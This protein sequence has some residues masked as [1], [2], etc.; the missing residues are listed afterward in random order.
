MGYAFDRAEAL[1][2]VHC[3]A[4]PILDGNGIPIAAITTT[5]P[6]YRLQAEDFEAIGKHSARQSRRH[7]KTTWFWAVGAFRRFQAIFQQPKNTT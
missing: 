2:G 6:A 4:A 3:I 5:G 7:F 1:E